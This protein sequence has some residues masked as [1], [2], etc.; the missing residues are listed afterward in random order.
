MSLSKDLFGAAKL[1]R[2]AAR[3]QDEQLY[4]VVGSELEEGVRKNGLWTKA[5][6]QSGGD[7]NKAQAIYIKLRVQSLKD[8]AELERQAEEV[9]RQNQEQIRAGRD[10]KAH[11]KHKQQ[12]IETQRKLENRRDGQQFVEP[13]EQQE[14]EELE[15]H[16][17]GALVATLGFFLIVFVFL[18]A[19]ITS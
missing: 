12:E 3:L 10:E 15:R 2:V 17:V 14:R 13:K 9:M 1:G 5:I 11:Q 6:S 4:E 19:L 16:Q 18:A 7:E 8:E